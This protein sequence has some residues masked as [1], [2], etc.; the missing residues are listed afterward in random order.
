MSRP[1]GVWPAGF[2]GQRLTGRKAHQ[3]RANRAIVGGTPSGGRCVPP[4]SGPIS[5]V[6]LLCRS[7]SVQSAAS[8]GSRRI[9]KRWLACV[10]ICVWSG[11]CA[12][13]QRREADFPLPTTT[14]NTGSDP[15]AQIDLK[16]MYLDQ[17]NRSARE[18]EQ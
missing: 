6:F 5:D 10:L 8:H 3:Q 1:K 14:V 9:L 4:G 18:R 2:D 16:L 15:L 13:A 11:V 17:M 7:N 12:N